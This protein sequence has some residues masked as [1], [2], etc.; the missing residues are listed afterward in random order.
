MYHT[1][2]V[3]SGGNAYISESPGSSRGTGYSF[4]RPRQLMELSISPHI[5]VLSSAQLIRHY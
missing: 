2:Y 5:N 3:S 1:E 4:N